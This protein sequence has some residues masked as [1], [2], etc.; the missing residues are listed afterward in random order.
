M[1]LLLIVCLIVATIIGQ[2]IVITNV[3]VVASPV[4]III[5]NLANV[6]IATIFSCRFYFITRSIIFVSHVIA[7]TMPCW[8]LLIFVS[9]SLKYCNCFCSISSCVRTCFFQFASWCHGFGWL[10]EP[11]PHYLFQLLP[12][13]FVNIC[14]FSFYPCVPHMVLGLNTK[15]I[16][17]CNRFWMV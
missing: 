9:W 15:N 8:F 6:A 16:I 5:V 13:T 7:R 17:C 4:A 11:K 14:W 3:V 12:P 1:L 10:I 2:T